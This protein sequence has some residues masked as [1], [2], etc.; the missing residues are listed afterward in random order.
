MRGREAATPLKPSSI[1]VGQ[2][3]SRT[4]LGYCLHLR[5][6]ITACAVLPKFLTISSVAV[7]ADVVVLQRL[8]TPA[9]DV[10]KVL[11]GLHL[12]SVWC[13]P[14]GCYRKCVLQFSST[15]AK[16]ALA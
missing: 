7:L 9:Y 14:G 13:S 4:L 3:Y 2:N 6:D 12:E 8:A 5:L 16:H 11:V 10:C 15:L 1:L